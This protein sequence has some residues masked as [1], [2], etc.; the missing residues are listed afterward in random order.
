MFPR[1]R[2]HGKELSLT[3]TSTS[4]ACV[5]VRR[6]V[7]DSQITG[8]RAARPRLAIFPRENREKTMAR[9]V[10]SL[11]AAL[12]LL[13][14]H[15]SSRVRAACCFSGQVSTAFPFSGSSLPAFCPE[16]PPPPPPPLRGLAVA[17]S[18]KGAS[19]AGRRC[20]FSTN[21]SVCLNHLVA[22]APH[23]CFKVERSP[24]SQGNHLL[25]PPHYDLLLLD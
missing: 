24:K 22:A 16:G 6:R 1:V 13:F 19:S 7:T 14:S 5:Q 18:A 23:R 4:A 17:K 15:R 3:S 20:P 25:L 9:A 12:K 21:F 8:E 2:S 10:R 11:P